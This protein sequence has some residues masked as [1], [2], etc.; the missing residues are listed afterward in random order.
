MT[1]KEFIKFSK[2]LPDKVS[3]KVVPIVG[4]PDILSFF[5]VK[6]IK[7]LRNIDTLKR[8]QMYEPAPWYY[9]IF[10]IKYVYANLFAER[11]DVSFGCGT[12]V[13]TTNKVLYSNDELKESTR[14]GFCASVH[15]YLRKYDSVL[16]VMKNKIFRI[17]ANTTT[18]P[19]DN[20]T[21]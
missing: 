6:N 15:N 17:Y 11:I 16:V 7:I 8:V 14:K 4:D 1:R 18:E 20:Q 9:R 3:A 21:A 2:S 13:F 5:K 10:G 12:H 19:A